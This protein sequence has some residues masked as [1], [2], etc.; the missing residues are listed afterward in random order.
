MRQH[1]L[2]IAGLSTVTLFRSILLYNAVTMLIAITSAVKRPTLSYR[3]IA[4]LSVCAFVFSLD[5]AIVERHNFF[6]SLFTVLFV[7]GMMCRILVNLVRF[8]RNGKR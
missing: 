8:R 5:Q 4:A 7:F 2:S 6:A 1:A 3:M